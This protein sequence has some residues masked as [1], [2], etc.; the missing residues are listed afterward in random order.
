ME[1]QLNYDCHEPKELESGDDHRGN[2]LIVALKTM[3]TTIYLYIAISL[4]S[5]HKHTD[6]IP[7]A[8]S[9]EFTKLYGG[10]GGNEMSSSITR[11][12]DGGYV[13]AGFSNSNDG[14]V[15][16][17]HGLTDAWVLGL[18]KDGNK[19]WQKSLGGSSYD[20]ANSITTTLDGG[21]AIAGYTHSNDGDVSGHLGI[22]DAWVVKLDQG[23]SILWQKTLGGLG[24]DNANDIVATNDSGYLIACETESLGVT[25]GSLDAW[26]V[27]LDK[28][29]NLLWQKA[30]GGSD[31]D[32]ISSITES[33][34]GGCVA[35]GYTRSDDGDVIGFPGF[36]D[37]W[38][39]K[40]DKDGN[41][42]W[43]KL[44]GGT[45]AE[46]FNSVVVSLDGGFVVAGGTRSSDGDVS[47]NRESF[48][49]WVVKLDQE[50]D[51][52]WQR[53][54]GGAGWDMGNS[55][56]STPDGSYIL[57]GGTNSTDGD[58]SGNHGAEDA[59]AVKLNRDGKILWQTTKGGAGS[60]YAKCVISSL[61]G[62]YVITGIADSNDGD[63]TGNHGGLDAWVFTLKDP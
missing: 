63:F 40:L 24:A 13:I 45:D 8:P 42:L 15:S 41:L 26:V 50:G 49:A 36:Q 2:I 46:A 55:V 39:V 60:D 25:H 59:W 32:G 58:V 23:G 31:L 12:I 9:P 21:Y 4:F 43:Q 10:T 11:S 18:D 34:D 29:G 22:A 61:Y 56:I 48:D 28:N 16:G 33:V 7:Q 44:L 6:F 57:A 52:L 5:C 19:L 51:I 38:V 20:A 27:K 3:R 54:L 35:A 53:P 14:D 30:L 62:G 37:G 47:G 17:N 1:K